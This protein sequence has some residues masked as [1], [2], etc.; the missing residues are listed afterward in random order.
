MEDFYYYASG[1]E[2]EPYS[3][4]FIES[5][6]ELRY[7]FNKENEPEELLANGWE[8]MSNGEYPWSITSPLDHDTVGIR[9]RINKHGF[10]CNEMPFAAA[11][12]AVIAL[13]SNMAFGVGVPEPMTWPHLVASK[14]GHRAITLAK[15][16]SSL[17]SQY[18]LLLAWLP[19]LQSEYVVLQEQHDSLSQ[20]ERFEGEELISEFIPGDVRPMEKIRRD[21]VLRAMQS[22]CNQFNSTFIHISPEVELL[23]EPDYGRDLMSPGRRQHRY[24]S[25]QVLKRMG[26]LD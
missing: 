21:M 5:D 26:Q 8:E 25:Y 12:R 7:E 1:Q 10:R 6:T 3:A 18:R 13:G 24:V 11:P 20:W 2:V 4:K 19:Q 9:Y 17:E 14:L 16:N 22:L 23:D 15:P